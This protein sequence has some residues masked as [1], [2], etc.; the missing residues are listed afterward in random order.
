[1]RW[2]LTWLCVTVPGWIDDWRARE[3]YMSAEWI[4]KQRYE[5]GKRSDEP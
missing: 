4:L 1:M 5:E 3:D 2:L